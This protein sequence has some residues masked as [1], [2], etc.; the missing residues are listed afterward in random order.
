MP[1]TDTALKPK[2]VSY[3]VRVMVC[4]L[5]CFLVSRPSTRA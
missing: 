5:A 3:I 1:P 2:N 4:P